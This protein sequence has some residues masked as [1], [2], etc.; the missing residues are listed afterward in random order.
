MLGQLRPSWICL[1]TLAV[2]CI[3]SPARAELRLCNF[4]P[5]RISVAL[6]YH[7][8]AVWVSTGWWGIGPGACQLV[9]AGD[10]KNRYYYVRATSD[11]TDFVWED[12][13]NFCTSRQ[14]FEV[15]G[16]RNCEARG[17]DSSRFFQ[18]DRGDRTNLMYPI[19]CKSC[20]WSRLQNVPP[21]SIGL[22]A[23]LRSTVASAVLW[24]D[25]QLPREY[26][27]SG[28]YADYG[29]YVFK[30]W[31]IRTVPDWEI[32]K[33]S[34]TIRFNIKYWLEVGQRVNKPWPLSGQMIVHLASCGLEEPLSEVAV[35][36]TAT[37]WVSDDARV[38]AS[39]R[40]ASL[41]SAQRC[42]L[43]VLN[44]DG[45]DYIERELDAQLTKLAA[46]FDSRIESINL[47]DWLWDPR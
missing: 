23:L 19:W 28:A 6:A 27:A 24:A 26:D 38:H 46:L 1:A 44:Y 43:T 5:E 17:Y 11:E 22:E 35:D 20:D 32:E 21:S 8:S 14:R 13:Y 40:V 42:L 33:N 3:A 29:G 30:Y 15:Q 36:M 34:V 9:V 37:F 2:V 18:I 25:G 10:L 7:N 4:S 31:A 12:N 41:T 47:R 39:T 16:D 45:S